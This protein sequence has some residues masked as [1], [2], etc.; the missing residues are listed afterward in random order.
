VYL[1]NSVGMQSHA[2]SSSRENGVRAGRFNAL[3]PVA[4]SVALVRNLKLIAK[5]SF[6]RD[7][8]RLARIRLDFLPYFLYDSSNFLKFLA[9]IWSPNEVQNPPIRN[10]LSLSDDE[11]TQNLKLFGS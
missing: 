6:R 9:V 3:R 10:G 7:V 5:P 1:W 2:L 4:A 8:T 11:G